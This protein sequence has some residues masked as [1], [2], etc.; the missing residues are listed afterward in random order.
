MKL[1]RWFSGEAKRIYAHIRESGDRRERRELVELIRRKEGRVRARDLQRAGRFQTSEDATQALQDLVN[2]R[3]GRWEKSEPGPTG[4]RPS[5]VFVLSGPPDVDT[6]D[7]TEASK[8]VSSDLSSVDRV[9]EEVAQEEVDGVSSDSSV[10]SSVS[11]VGDD[12]GEEG[13]SSDSSVLSS[14]SNVGD[15]IGEE[16]G[17]GVSSSVDDRDEVGED[18]EATW[19][20]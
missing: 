20:A 1:T 8:T 16:E 12:I 19:T 6:T 2:H 7:K 4:G 11:N 17:H 3:L 15:D 18:E 10:L 9:E 13:V 14:V 5:R